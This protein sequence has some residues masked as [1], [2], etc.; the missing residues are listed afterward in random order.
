MTREEALVRVENLMDSARNI[1]DQMALQM[2]L[3]D[4]WELDELEQSAKCIEI[5]AVKPLTLDELQALDGDKIYI[6]Y[7]GAC[8]G[9]Y[10]DG[11]APYFGRHALA[12]QEYDGAIH[13][14]NL[15]LAQ[16]GKGW[17][18]YRHKPKEV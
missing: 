4:M 18:A 1:K 13:A 15:P 8:Q 3:D 9:F 2:A 7:I 10:K 5:E 6:H 17:L 16:Y 14:C 11:F 12:V